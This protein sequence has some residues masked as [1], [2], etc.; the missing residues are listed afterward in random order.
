LFIEIIQNIFT[1]SYKSSRTKLEYLNKASDL[2]DTLKFLLQILW[3]IKSLETKKY[4]V[5]S[6]PLEEAGRMLGG[7]Q[8]KQESRIGILE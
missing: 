1:A 7:W 3:E 4:V 8:K 2:L 5:L 6:S